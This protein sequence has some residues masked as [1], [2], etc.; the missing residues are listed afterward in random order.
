MKLPKIL[1]FLLI[2]P[3]VG[4]ILESC[5]TSDEGCR[6][7]IYYSC[8]VEAF[9][10]GQE[11]NLPK[12]N[13]RMELYFVM[14]IHEDSVKQEY[15]GADEPYCERYYTK[16]TVVAVQIFS[17]KDFVT[18]DSV[19]VDVT[20]KFSVQSWDGD[21]IPYYEDDPTINCVL[22][23]PPSTAGTYTF[24]VVAQLSD[25]RKLEQSIEAEL[26]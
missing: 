2:F 26:R 15:P 18:S 5:D 10:L 12:E 13:Y 9:I 8:S 7:Y 16:D 20:D 23:S 21:Y 4:L 25:G 24:T 11:E 19:N 14:D 22:I 1:F 3:L 6:R 17:D